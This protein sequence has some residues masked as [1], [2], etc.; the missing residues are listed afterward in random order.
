MEI[1]RE[2]FRE[3]V[4]KFRSSFKAEALDTAEKS[5]RL[6]IS[7]VAVIASGQSRNMRWIADSDC[8]A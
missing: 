7:I 6:E 4:K 8:M 3:E 2:S 5:I 1:N